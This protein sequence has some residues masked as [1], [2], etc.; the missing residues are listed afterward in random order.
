MW[1]EIMSATYL[2]GHRLNVLFTD[3]ARRIFD[4]MPLIRQY[5]VFSPLN[6]INTFKKFVVTDTL[7][8]NNGTIDIAPEYIYEHGTSVG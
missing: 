4:F 7:E 2:D 1:K 5:A 3:G 6:D 8:W